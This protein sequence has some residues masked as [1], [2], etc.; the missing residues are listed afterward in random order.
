MIHEHACVVRILMATILTR[1]YAVQGG[2]RHAL[3]CWPSVPAGALAQHSRRARS[4]CAPA[5]N[6]IDTPAILFARSDKSDSGESTCVPRHCIC[7][8]DGPSCIKMDINS[9]MVTPCFSFE[10][11]LYS[12][13]EVTFFTRCAV[14]LF[15]TKVL[16]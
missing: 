1:V 8:A 15:D 10:L 16:P 6:S 4:W 7:V 14:M 5:D 9:D 12:D 11:Q 13:E 2:L 3:L